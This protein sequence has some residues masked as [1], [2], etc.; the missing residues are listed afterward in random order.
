MRHA[1]AGGGTVVGAVSQVPFQEQ[2][3]ARGLLAR[4][5]SGS[6]QARLLLSSAQEEH[7][8][9]PKALPQVSRT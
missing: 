6:C 5:K 4:S 1:H 8:G 9:F 7:P 3:A 2:L